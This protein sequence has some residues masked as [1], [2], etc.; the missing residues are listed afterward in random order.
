[1]KY[2]GIADCHGL[3]SFL[4]LERN[5]DK[6]AYLYF[7]AQANRHRLAVVYI[8]EL[9]DEAAEVIKKLFKDRKYI[10][11]LKALKSKALEVRFPSREQQCYSEFWSQIPNPVLDPWYR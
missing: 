4:E 5:R 9:S 3:E 6:L 7:R 11:A 8:A 1:M 2:C 10:A